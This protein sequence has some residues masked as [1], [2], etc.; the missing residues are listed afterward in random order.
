MEQEVIQKLTEYFASRDEVVL[1]YL[2]GSQVKGTASAVRSDYDVAIYFKPKTGV[3]EYEE[4]EYSVTDYSYDTESIIQ[5]D[6][7][8]I[9]NKDVD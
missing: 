2:F 4:S 7:E 8:K 9:T 6:L 1:A 3:F 5:A